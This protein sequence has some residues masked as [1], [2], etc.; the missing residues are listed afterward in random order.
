MLPRQVGCECCCGEPQSG[1]TE[2]HVAVDHY[3]KLNCVIYPVGIYVENCFFTIS[4]M[5]SHPHETGNGGMLALPPALRWH[6][7]LSL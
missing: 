1:F 2:I 5:L 3:S 6:K 7:A 4:R